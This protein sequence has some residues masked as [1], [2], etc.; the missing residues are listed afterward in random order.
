MYETG[1]AFSVER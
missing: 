1:L